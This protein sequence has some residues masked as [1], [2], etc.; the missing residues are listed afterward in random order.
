MNMVDNNSLT[1]ELLFPNQLSY[2]GSFLV[3]FSEQIPHPV[4]IK[5]LENGCSIQDMKVIMHNKASATA[6]GF[7]AGGMIG[8]TIPEILDNTNNGLPLDLKMKEIELQQIKKNDQEA[9]NNDQSTC[10]QI[11]SDGQGCIRMYQRISTILNGYK[12]KPIALATICLEITNYI[13][14]FDLLKLYKKYYGNKTKAVEQFSLHFN[15]QAYFSKTLCH[16]EL[17]TLLK[18]IEDPRHKQVAQTLD[19]SC[20]TVA[21]YLSSIKNKLR[22]NI[23]IYMVLCSL[24][25]YYKFQLDPAILQ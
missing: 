6:R 14:L 2:L 8:M 13:N 22:A 21:S 3:K 18:M 1:A 23:D 20:N 15:L 16:E 4:S 10:T 11:V 24:R 9:I 19:I 7:N 17:R 25:N 5:S 12:G